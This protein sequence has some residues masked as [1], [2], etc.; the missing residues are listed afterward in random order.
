MT[1]HRLWWRQ[2]FSDPGYDPAL[3][4]L[5]RGI[6]GGYLVI[7]L[8]ILASTGNPLPLL[9]GVIVGVPLKPMV[10]AWLNGK[11]F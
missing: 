7:M 2:E 8:G 6:V 1:S 5:A 11:D 9:A 4:W 3:A 10:W